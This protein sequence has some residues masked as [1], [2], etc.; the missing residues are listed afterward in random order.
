MK[1]YTEKQLLAFAQTNRT[2]LKL[3]YEDKRF[4]KNKVVSLE[5]E[6]F[7]FEIKHR[8][9]TYHVAYEND[10]IDDYHITFNCFENAYD[11]FK[12]ELKEHGFSEVKISEDFSDYDPNR[13]IE[14]EPMTREEEYA[15]ACFAES[16]GEYLPM[17]MYKE[18]Y[19]IEEEYSATNPWNAPGMSIKDFI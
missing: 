9:H 12:R 19:H 7:C 3:W 10:Y 18:K 8:T 1:T 13:Y 14:E 17:Q 4:F 16:C 11:F 6:E 15:E 5:S 2:S